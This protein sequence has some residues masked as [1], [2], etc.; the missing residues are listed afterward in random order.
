M[1]LTYNSCAVAHCLICTQ[2]LRGGWSMLAQRVE[3]E[4]SI[5]SS[6]LALCGTQVHYTRH[7]ADGMDY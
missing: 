2:E 3:G 7:T 4:D 1:L 5:F 6:V